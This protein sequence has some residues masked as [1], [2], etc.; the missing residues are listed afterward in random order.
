MDGWIDPVVAVDAGLLRKVGADGFG[1]WL[2]SVEIP[3][4]IPSLRTLEAADRGDAHAL[5]HARRSGG[6]DRG[7]GGPEIERL[8]AHSIDI[9]ACFLKEG[10]L[11]CLPARPFTLSPP[12]AHTRPK[13]I[14]RAPRDRSIFDS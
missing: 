12:L 13:K 7:R 8:H 1:G 14:A 2:V 4:Q 11:F 6:R 9:T 3:S 5:M 10:T